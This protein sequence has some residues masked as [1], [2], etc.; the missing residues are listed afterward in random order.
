VFVFGSA[1]VFEF[2]VVVIEVV[3]AVADMGVAVFVVVVVVVVVVVAAVFVF[4]FESII[5]FVFVLVLM[6]VGVFVFGSIRGHRGNGKNL[7]NEFALNIGS[8]EGL[9]NRGAFSLREGEYNKKLGK[10]IGVTPT[11]LGGDA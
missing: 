10:P 6:L 8:L 7:I 2:V 9:Q 5:E 11:S 4:V 3:V 1:I